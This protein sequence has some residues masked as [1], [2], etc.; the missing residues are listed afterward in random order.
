MDQN[1]YKKIQCLLVPPKWLKLKTDH[2]KY[3]QEC[4]AIQILMDC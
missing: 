2:T 4:G 3:W 1:E